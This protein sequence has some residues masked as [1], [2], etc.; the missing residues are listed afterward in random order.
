M[1]NRGG[2]VSSFILDGTCIPEETIFGRSEPMQRVRTAV[3]RVASTSVPVLIQ[4][5]SGTGK[6]V[7]A[8]DIHRRS[9]WAD[10][11]FVKVSCP[12]IPATL[13]ESEL[14]GY[15]KGAFTGAWN[16]KP[17]RVELADRGTLLLDEIGEMELSLQAKLLQLLQDGQFSRIGGQHDCQVDVRIVCVTNRSLEHE[18]AAGNFRRDL[19]Y[20]INVVSLRLPALRERAEDIP[21]LAN[22]FLELYSRQHDRE[23]RPF[24]AELLTFICQHNWPGNIRELENSVKRYVIMGSEAEIINE[25]VPQKYSTGSSAEEDDNGLL[26][27]KVHTKRARQELERELILKALRQTNWNRKKAARMLQISYRALLYKVKMVGLA[28]KRGHSLVPVENGPRKEG[29]WP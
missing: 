25:S 28:S 5:E 9:P 20:R 27:L 12:A 16:A 22:Y 17:G 6:E 3:E 10:G 14:F 11:P 13:L 26:P 24:S 1:W 8:K 7:I 21:Q 18:I 19:Y 4:G 15:E 23:V 2:R 29:R